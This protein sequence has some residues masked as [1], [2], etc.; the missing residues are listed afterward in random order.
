[1]S[2]FR[3]EDKVNLDRMR[4][5]RVQKAKEQMEKDGIGA[6]LCFN[7]ANHKYL[8]DTFTTKMISFPPRYVLFPRT[9]DPILYEM[10]GRYVRVRDELAPWLKGNVRPPTWAGFYVGLGLEPKPFLDDLQRT[11][12]EYDI[13]KEPLAIDMPLSTLN[14]GDIFRKAGIN[15]VDGG[16]SLAKAR[17]IKTQ[18]EIECLRIST[19]ITEEIFGAIREAIK[20]GVTENQLAGM[21]NEIELSR[22][23]DN[24]DE[25]VVCSGENTHPNMHVYNNRPIRPGDMIF[26]DI[27]MNW[28]GYYSCVYRTFTCGPATQHQKEIHEECRSLLY[29]GLEKVKAG[30]TTADIIKAW[31]GPEHWGWKTWF[32]CAENAMGHGIGLDLHE[33]PG[34]VSL[35]SVDYPVKLVENMTL[36][37]ETYYGDIPMTIPGQGARLEEDVVVTKDGFELLTKWPINEITEAW[38]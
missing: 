33:G 4:R 9:G 2:L 3:T 17:M 29:K 34:I 27:H 12:S 37:V 6:Y 35:F 38:I 32:Q 36:A 1:M 30:N 7:A 24:P 15:A 11:L 26:F 10:G 16:A 22:G 8:T 18:D 21:I 13:L 31:P 23:A 14:F 19:A 5:E 20:P 25:P 28:R